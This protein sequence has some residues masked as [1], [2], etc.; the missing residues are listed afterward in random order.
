M[1]LLDLAQQIGALLG[2]VGGTGGAVLA[3]KIRSITEAIARAESA[4]GRAEAA[5][6]R[7]EAIEAKIK[8]IPVSRS[9]P[10]PGPDSHTL[11]RA[12]REQYDSIRRT[13]KHEWQ[14]WLDETK[15]ELAASLRS[16]AD[17]AVKRSRRSS[18][19]DDADPFMQQ[20]VTNL[21]R[22]LDNIERQFVEAT[23]ERTESWKAFH[24]LVGE[25]RA[26][27]RTA[28]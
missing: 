3:A 25:M 7:A 12:V 2:V 13:Q 17:A 19:S 5:E 15:D 21:E 24:Q 10:P 28:R 4:A 1:S 22:R 23:S 8:S 26:I 20:Q 11:E 16:E 9:A 27:I 14:R 6:T 18:Q